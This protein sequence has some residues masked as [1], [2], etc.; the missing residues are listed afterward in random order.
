MNG[1][2]AVKSVR[3]GRCD[4]RRAVAHQTRPCRGSKVPT[5][6]MDIVAIP[7]K[8]R[9]KSNQLEFFFTCQANR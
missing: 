1:D 8:A 6:Q 7:L 3:E 5:A 9:W 4:D 2:G